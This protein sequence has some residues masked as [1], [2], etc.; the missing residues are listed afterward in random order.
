MRCAECRIVVRDPPLL[1]CQTFDELL[2]LK[3]GGHTIYGGPLGHESASLISYFQAIP[4]VPRITAAVNPA[5]WMLEISTV[6][7]EARLQTDL[8]DAFRQSQQFR[9]AGW[10]EGSNALHHRAAPVDAPAS[11]TVFTPK[12]TWA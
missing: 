12:A 10:G 6:T 5:T 11:G 9:Y 3:R 1:G 4:G 7:A 8:A 2:L